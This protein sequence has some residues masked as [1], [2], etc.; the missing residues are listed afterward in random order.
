MKS[1]EEMTACVLAARDAIL[2]KRRRQRTVLLCC[3]PVVFC[4]A[5]AGGFR[6]YLQRKPL[7]VQQSDPPAV[8]IHAE[9]EHPADKEKQSAAG[10]QASKAQAVQTEPDNSG[11]ISA[12]AVTELPHDVPQTELADQPDNETAPEPLTEADGCPDTHAYRPW[13]DLAVNQQYFGAD[14]GQIPAENGADTVYYQT[15]EQ[16]VPAA[17]VG[18]YLCEAFMSGYD[19]YDAD[20]DRYYHCYAKAYRITGHEPGDAVA[21]RFAEDGAY[22]LYE[23]TQPADG[24]ADGLTG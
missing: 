23:H 11:E 6:A 3:L 5:A 16:A 14:I 19:F 4:A 21:I 7:T 22:Y 1:Y 20:A 24:A 18:E 9:T 17:E 10:E 2:R 13:D 8:S 15:A 12:A